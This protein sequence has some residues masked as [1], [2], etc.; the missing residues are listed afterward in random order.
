VRTAFRQTPTQWTAAWL[1]LGAA[2]LP[3]APQ[4][5]AAAAAE[6]CRDDRDSPADAPPPAEASVDLQPAQRGGD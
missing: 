1:L 4:E 5:L 2:A 3:A 6:P